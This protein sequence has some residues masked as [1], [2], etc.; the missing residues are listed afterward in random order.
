MQ[1]ALETS[2]RQEQHKFF[3]TEIK[4][5]ETNT[6][7]KPQSK[8]SELYP[9]LHE[10]ILWVGAIQVPKFDSWEEQISK[11][12]YLRCSSLTRRSHTNYCRN[13]NSFLDTKLQKSSAQSGFKLRDMFA[14]YS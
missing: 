10:G 8:L 14:I 12:G 5:L 6:Q 13:K 2:L 11:T 3:S 1:E 4:T 9:F 7:V